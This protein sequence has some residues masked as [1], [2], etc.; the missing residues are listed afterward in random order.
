MQIPPAHQRFAGHGNAGAVPPAGDDGSNP[1]AAH[2]GDGLGDGQ[3]VGAFAVPRDHLRVGVPQLSDSVVPPG[4]HLVVRGEG[5]GVVTPRPDGYLLDG[6]V[7]EGVEQL[8]EE[9]VG[10]REAVPRVLVLAER[11]DG[12]GPRKDAG[13]HGAGVD[14]PHGN[15]REVLDMRWHAPVL[16]VPMAQP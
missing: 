8:G 4:P 7:A 9:D 13:V 14:L 12:A 11:V 5:D 3:E 10:L 2:A 6:L 1:G 16:Y 15:E